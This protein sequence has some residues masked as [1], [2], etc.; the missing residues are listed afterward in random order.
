MGAD[1]QVKHPVIYFDGIC[2]LCNAS[3]NFIIKR[4][5]K[6]HYKFASLQSEYA[7]ENLP[8]ELTRV[9][10]LPTLVLIDKNIKTRSTAALTIAKHLSG[11]WPLIYIFII[12]PPFIRDFF[13]DL[14]AKNRYKL[15]GKRDHCMIPTPELKDR[16]MD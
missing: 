14:I 7:V 2:N 1:N 16:F 15:F 4:D 5:P 13:Y 9:G 8:D 3:I 12:L 10:Q 6:G 11:L